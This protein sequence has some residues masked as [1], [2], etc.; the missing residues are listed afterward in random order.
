[1]ITNL[2]WSIFDYLAEK[3]GF[4]QATEF[5]DTDV[6]QEPD[7]GIE[8]LTNL[9]KSQGAT[10]KKLRGFKYAASKDPQA[11]LKVLEAFKE[12]DAKPLPEGTVREGRS[13]SDE[14]RSLQFEAAKMTLH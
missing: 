4:K 1:M 12:L 11:A 5:F 7:V 14:I 10:D 9:F 13:L 8:A 3:P 2:Q 6:V